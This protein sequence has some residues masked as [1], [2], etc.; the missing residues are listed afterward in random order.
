MSSDRDAT[1][2]SSGW[3]RRAGQ[4][5]VVGARRGGDPVGPRAMAVGIVALGPVAP[6]VVA[7]VVVVPDHDHRMAQVQ[8]LR[9]GIGAQLGQP[10]R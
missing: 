4:P 2:G 3:R 1:S 8:G 6:G 10:G 7:D 9:V 5:L